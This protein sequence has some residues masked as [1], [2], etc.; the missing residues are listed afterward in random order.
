MT[1]IGNLYTTQIPEYTEAADIVKAFNLYH[2]G[3][4][5]VPTQ[6][7]QISITPPASIAGW[8][9]KLSLDITNLQAGLSDVTTLANNQNLNDIKSTALYLST[10]NPT[11][12]L[13][14]PTE[15]LGHLNVV[16]KSNQTFQTYQTTGTLNNFYV[17]AGT[18]AAG[19]T[20]WAP[21]VLLS[22]DGHTHDSRYYT[23]NE[24]DLK[25]SNT[26]LTS[27]RVPVTNS[28]GII[29]TSDI[30]STELNALDGIDPSFTIEER[31]E[32]KS[33]VTHLH[34]GRYYLRSD[35]TDPQPGAQRVPR[36]FVQSAQPSGAQAND[37]WFW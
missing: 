34:D 4:E 1:S 7:S 24:I 18:T 3:T 22:K 27:S 35:V 12:A 32:D 29:V 37:L 20:A 33:D 6:D 36:I 11:I 30:T 19:V 2:Y 14:Y 21:W 10:S 13:N 25:I 23:K 28:N 26:G 16:N 15:A 9:K 5:T 31:L 8:I 17:R